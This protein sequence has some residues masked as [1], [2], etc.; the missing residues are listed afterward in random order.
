[1]FRDTTT[2]CFHYIPEHTTSLGKSYEDN[3]SKL[4]EQFRKDSLK[5]KYMCL[6]ILY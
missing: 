6:Y 4:Q 3:L 1:M 2:A 5:C